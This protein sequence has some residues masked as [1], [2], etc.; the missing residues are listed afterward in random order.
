MCKNEEKRAGS[1]Q[2]LEQTTTSLFHL[3]PRAATMF[4]REVTLVNLH[5]AFQ[6][7]FW[8]LRPHLST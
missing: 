2:G 8:E 3:C 1:T 5:P 6:L 7:L 4:F